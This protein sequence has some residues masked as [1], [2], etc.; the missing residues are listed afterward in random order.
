MVPLRVLSRTNLAGS[1]PSTSFT[2]SIS[3][4]SFRLRTLD[5]SLRSFSDSRRLFSITSALFLQNTRG[6]IPLPE[7]VRCTEAQKCLFVSPLPATLTH[8]VSRKS[9]PCHSYANTRDGGVTVP[10]VSPSASLCLPVRQAGLGELCGESVASRA[11]VEL[12]GRPIEGFAENGVGAQE[13]ELGGAQGCR[14]IPALAQF[15]IELVHQLR[16]RGVV[17]FPERRDD[18]VRAGAQERPGEPDQT[19]PGVGARAGAIAGRNRHEVRRERMLDD[20]ARVQLERIA[21]RTQNHRGIQRMRAAGASV[22]DKMQVRK[23]LR[24]PLQESGRRGLWSRKHFAARIAEIASDAIHFSGRLP[25]HGKIVARRDG[26]PDEQKIPVLGSAVSARPEQSERTGSAECYVLDPEMRL[27]PRH[28][29]SLE[30]QPVETSIRQQN[31][32]RARWDKFLRRLDQQRVKLL[33]FG[34]ATYQHV[35][36][37]KHRLPVRLDQRIKLRRAS[38]R[39]ATHLRRSNDPKIRLLL[40]Q[41]IKQQNRLRA[42]RGLPRLKIA[43][44]KRK[45]FWRGAETLGE[46][47]RPA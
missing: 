25:Q 21:V 5:F 17:D 23:A 9:F 19:F 24:P 4:A 8:S 28:Q 37:A 46:S 13:G 20:V 18:V 27:R 3:F 30:V 44:R 16:R 32:P 26:V 11:G 2:S 43:Q 38:Q 39:Q 45:S 10:P 34:A 12:E 33:P 40:P 42:L 31:R 47:A 7:L 41:P 1:S 6:G 35:P 15:S 29:Q 22:R 36:P 14:G